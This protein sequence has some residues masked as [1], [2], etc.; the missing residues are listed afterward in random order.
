LRRRFLLLVLLGFLAVIPVLWYFFSDTGGPLAQDFSLTDLEGNVFR[1]SDFRG[2]VVVVEFM[3]TW[4]AFC[5]QQLSF[6]GEDWDEYAGRVVLIIIDVDVR[7]TEHTLSIYASQFPHRDWIWA[8]D[9][10]N[11][12]RSY[13]VTAIPKTVI[14]D[15]NGRIRSSHTGLMSPASFKDEIEKLLG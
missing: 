7:E 4:C 9:T 8:M 14:I 12:V 11:L 10:A 15:Q 13:G 3:A 2:K 6:F 1:L 5:R